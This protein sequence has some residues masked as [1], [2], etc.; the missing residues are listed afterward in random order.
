MKLATA[1]VEKPWGRTALPANFG[2]TGGRRMGELWFDAPR[3]LPLLVKTI[4]TS[5]RLSIQVHPDDEQAR[6]RGLASGKSE[7]WYIL[8]ADPDAKLGL[9]LTRELSRPELR[10]AALNGSIERLLEWRPVRPGDFFSVP[11]RTIHAIGGGITL[12]EVQQNQGVTFRLYDY[13]RPRELHV[14]DAVAV[15]D[16][17]PYPSDAAR[18]VEQSAPGVLLNGPHFCVIHGVNGRPRAAT[19]EGRRRWVMP[20]EGMVRSGQDEAEQG[21]CLLLEAGED[22]EFDGARIL[23][24]AAGAL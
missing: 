15:A 4:F 7:C 5:E 2:A 10:A 20:L 12:L 23:I 8:D 6:E 9:G 3:D 19:L 14:D 18:H 13:G 11:A 22:L 24:A 21:D 1:W 16:P 17:R